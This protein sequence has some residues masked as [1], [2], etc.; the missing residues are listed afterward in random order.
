MAKPSK[1]KSTEAKTR[2]ETSMQ[3]EIYRRIMDKYYSN[4]MRDIRAQ[5]EAEDIEAAK[6]APAKVEP[7]NDDAE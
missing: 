4:E 1:A 3:A 7:E 6:N 5:I 2:S